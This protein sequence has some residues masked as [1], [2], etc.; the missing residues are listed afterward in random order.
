MSFWD[1]SD[2][3]KLM[4]ILKILAWGFGY[5]MVIVPCV[6]IVALV[7]D[8]VLEK[9]SDHRERKRSKQQK[10][11]L[12]VYTQYDVGVSSLDAARNSRQD[13]K[14]VEFFMTSGEVLHNDY[15]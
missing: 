9:F 11:Q 10:R 7:V 4:L 3:E 6:I 14:T 15:R 5:A 13:Q 12:D 8:V 1:L 2:T